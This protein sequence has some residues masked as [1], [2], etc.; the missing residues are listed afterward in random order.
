LRTKRPSSSVD[1]LL[2]ALSPQQV[3][4]STA[5]F[6][7]SRDPHAMLPEIK[8]SVTRMQG[9]E[10]AQFGLVL[11]YR[12]ADSDDFPITEPSV[13]ASE[14]LRIIEADP[15]RTLDRFARFLEHNPRVLRTL[16][17]PSIREILLPVINSR[18]ADVEGTDIPD[19][20]PYTLEL[21]SAL[22]SIVP[23]VSLSSVATPFIAIGSGIA[24]A[25]R[26]V[27]RLP[28]AAWRGFI[29]LTTL[30]GRAFMA[31]LRGVG[32]AAVFVGRVILAPFIA[33]GKAFVALGRLIAK[34][35]GVIGLAITTVCR[36]LWN[37][38]RAAGRAVMLPVVALGKGFVAV[39]RFIARIPLFVGRGFVHVGRAIAAALVAMAKGIAFAAR[40][41]GR[42]IGSASRS[43]GRGAVNASHATAMAGHS[44]AQG[45]ATGT[46]ATGKGL[47]AGSRFAGS[48]ALRIGSTLRRIAVAIFA[49]ITVA[50]VSIARVLA[51]ATQRSAVAVR[52]SATAGASASRTA[53]RAGGKALVTSRKSAHVLSEKTSTAIAAARTVSKDRFAASSRAATAFGMAAGTALFGGPADTESRETKR[54]SPRNAIVDRLR[55]GMQIAARP[56]A[57]VACGALVVIV[58]VT[59]VAPFINGLRTHSDAITVAAAAPHRI[60]RPQH[61]HPRVHRVVVPKQITR[62]K[63]YR[64]KTPIRVAVAPHRAVAPHPKRGWK[65]DPTFNP[66]TSNRRVAFSSMP[67]RSSRAAA[68]VPIPAKE[69]IFVSRARL[70][71]TS[72][73]A[74]LMRGDASTALAHLGLSANA[75]VSNLSEGPVVQRAASF[76]IVH[77][78]LRNGGTAKIDVEITGPQG[79]YFG[80]YTV[81]ANGPAAWITDHTVIPTGSTVAVHR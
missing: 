79:R 2:S 35:P 12:P 61:H 18:Q 19:D 13:D 16:D 45:I 17:P 69:P 3:A 14:L 30:L 60:A 72:Y 7:S 27:F 63:I 81:Q 53:A 34:V 68:P 25:F 11:G 4:N 58:G 56:L 55:A 6:V 71:V 23:L 8:R 33:I 70:I 66:F 41:I 50:A 10:R 44:V 67:R 74:S 51:N 22:Q 39:V 29:L 43:V 36:A 73:L 48:A 38:V 78:I 77:A 49:A 20:A 15:S 37:G 31:L 64:A 5:S 42:T 54:P 9:S 75:P 57:V 76:K 47:S 65:F 1:Y 80:V 52:R 62:A 59:I 40:G 28:L 32:V 26:F 21:A 24:D 46:L